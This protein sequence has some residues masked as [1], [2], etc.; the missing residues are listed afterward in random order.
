M[1]IGRRALVIAI[2]VV[3]AP[4]E[5]GRKRLT[6]VELVFGATQLMMQ[7]IIA[8]KLKHMR[9]AVLLRPPVSGFRV[10]DFLK[11]ESVLAE[12]AAL[13]DDLKRAIDDAVTTSERRKA[14]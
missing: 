12:T 11:I 2:D 14:G 6:G 10:L 4:V 5:G 9:P 8:M 1:T 7:S 3:G 13:K